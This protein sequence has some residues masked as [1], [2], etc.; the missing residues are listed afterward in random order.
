M[1]TVFISYRHENDAHVRRVREF[2]ERLRL[3]L[4]QL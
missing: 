4:T 3:A 2:G 1:S